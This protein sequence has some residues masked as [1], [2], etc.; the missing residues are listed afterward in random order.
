MLSY[1]RR[2]AGSWMIKVLLV[3][4]ALSFVIGFGVLPTL[5]DKQGEGFVV[6]QV[7]DRRVT[8][9]EWNRAYQNMLSSYR[10]IYQDRFSDEMAKQLRL[11]DK[12]LDNL[13]NQ[14]LLL[15]EAEHMNLVVSDEELQEIIRSL[16]YFQ[17]EGRFDKQQYLRLLG[18]NR[19]N[20]S[21]FETLQREELLIRRLQEII[22]GTV[23]VSEEELWDQYGLE[24]EEVSLGAVVIDP[25]EFED[26]VEVTEEDLRQYFE[27][28]KEDYLTPE[29]AKVKYVYFPF[30][31][32]RDQ[33][34]VY[35]G[36]IEDY[37][38]LHH[39]EFSHPEE[40][41]L[42]H[43]LL[44]VA[45]PGDEALVQEKSKILEGLRERIEKGE[46]FAQLA[47]AHSEDTS[48]GNGGDLGYLKRG[49]LVP[50]VEAAA[51]SLKPG[52]VSGIVSSSY[53][54][55][56]LKVEEYR[57]ADVDPLDEVSDGIM[58]KL[59]EEKSWR[60]AR[61]KAEEF[62][63]EAKKGDVFNRPASEEQ[64]GAVV[65]ETGFFSRGEEVSSLGGPEPA[66]Q[67]TAFLLE[68][69]NMSEAVKGAKGYYILH[70]IERKSPEVLL[71]DQAKDRV[72]KRFRT[73]RSKDLAEEKAEAVMEM[74]GKGK[75]LDEI[76]AEEGLST[77]DTGAF[78]RQ[79]TYVPRIGVSPELVAAAFSLSEANP[80][81]DRPYEI[82][83]K[84]YVVRM[85]EHKL[86]ERAAF[87]AEKD[88]FKK[89]QKQR[90]GQEVF[91]QWLS[92]LRELSDVQIT[93]LS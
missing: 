23:K 40:L 62:I 28:T 52:E 17:K 8:R 81:A 79:R 83:G 10:Q 12:A 89:K 49:E 30:D 6:A 39:D 16:P 45:S 63:W 64:E 93:P 3:G 35:T 75:N 47:K 33:V 2:N 50:E 7:G 27:K 51:F 71:F 15:Q 48:A 68:E 73:Y 26:A 65:K 78:T 34:K 25:E 85:K 36:D 90:K 32:Y 1:M 70:L 29:K 69:G 74:A 67:T 76:A 55:H 24:K 91:N 37:Y 42:R 53:G 60:L 66:F 38:N 80:L 82:N 21:E 20:P 61:R 87:L 19:L 56:L 14:A 9:G 54:L 41:H 77:L 18:M 88:D 11:R 22:E 46:D 86:P 84:L 72:E 13:I 44:R 43:I 57:A 92:E 58:E 59:T 31:D 4:V 5:R